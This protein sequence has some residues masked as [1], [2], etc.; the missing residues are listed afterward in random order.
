[1]TKSNYFDQN[2]NYINVENLTLAGIYFKGMEA[3]RK[4]TEQVNISDTT[5][6]KTPIAYNSHLDLVV[7]AKCCRAELRKDAREMAY[8]PGCGRKVVDEDQEE[9]DEEARREAMKLDDNEDTY[10]YRGHV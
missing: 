4:A 5:Y 3:G 10:K 2:G 9:A 7:C 6:W 8:C 1:M